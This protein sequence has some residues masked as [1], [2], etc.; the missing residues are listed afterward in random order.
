MNNNFIFFSFLNHMFLFLS[1]KHDVIQI[2]KIFNSW[3]LYNNSAPWGQTNRIITRAHLF[4]HPTFLK[5]LPFHHT[6]TCF[7]PTPPTHLISF[8]SH[9][10]TW[11]YLF[12]THC[13]TMHHDTRKHSNVLVFAKESNDK[14]RLCFALF[15]LKFHL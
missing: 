2:C 12:T 14:I 8:W 5:C 4:K 6:P 11:N 15:V 10:Q 13:L 9:W 1:E 7:P 3:N